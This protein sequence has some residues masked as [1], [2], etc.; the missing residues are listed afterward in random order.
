MKNSDVRVAFEI[1]AE[2][3]GF[4]LRYNGKST[5]NGKT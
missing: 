1:M 3:V 4:C 2:R 5:N